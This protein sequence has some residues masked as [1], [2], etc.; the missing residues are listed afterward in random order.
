VETEAL[1]KAVH[2]CDLEVVAS[3]EDDEPR[4]SPIRIQERQNHLMVRLRRAVDFLAS[5]YEEEGAD[6]PLQV[7]ELQ[8]H[9][10]VLLHMQ[11]TELPIF[12]LWID[13]ED[14][15][16]LGNIDHKNTTNI[17]NGKDWVY[18]AIEKEATPKKSLK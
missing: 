17:E 8:N 14:C 9:Q 5:I 18:R 3:K 15:I 1:T 12:K 11:N 13:K 2:L 7:E 10:Y 6:L 16:D 4:N